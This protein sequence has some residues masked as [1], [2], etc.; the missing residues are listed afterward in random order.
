M[1][2]AQGNLCH[3]E[4]EI[5]FSSVRAAAYRHAEQS[6]SLLAEFSLRQTVA[7]HCAGF[8]NVDIGSPTHMKP[9]FSELMTADGMMPDLLSADGDGFQMS[10]SGAC[11]GNYGHSDDEDE[12]DDS[13]LDDYDSL[14]DEEIPESSVGDNSDFQDV[15]I[16][17][18]DADDDECYPLDEYYDSHYEESSAEGSAFNRCCSVGESFNRGVPQ[19]HTAD[20][21]PRRF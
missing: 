11:E 20:G 3:S 12:D 5:H 19:D 16:A 7:P 13:R 18:E 6:V 4:Q 10:S 21:I 1:E 2:E 8:G 15:D 17:S 9:N 14:L